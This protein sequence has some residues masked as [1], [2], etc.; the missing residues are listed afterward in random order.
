M[1]AEGPPG[2]CSFELS[3]PGT[4]VDAVHHLL[5][6]LLVLQD[7]RLHGTDLVLLVPDQL[8][9]LRQLRLQGLHSAVSDAAG[10]QAG[11]RED[12]SPFPSDAFRRAAFGD[13]SSP[14]GD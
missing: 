5:D 4:Q 6:L 7:V 1:Q 10:T 2:V 13:L 11:A 9:Q 3:P 14:T 12:L 8:L